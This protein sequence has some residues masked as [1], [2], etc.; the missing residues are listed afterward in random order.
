M[1]H[2]FGIFGLAHGYAHPSLMERSHRHNEIEL[3]FVE[4]GVMTYLFGG[5]QLMVVAGRLVLFWA[6]I[7]HQVVHIEQ[8]VSLHWL[9]VPLAWFL[10]WG[11]PD[12]LTRQVLYGR[13]MV[14]QGHPDQQLDKMLF[15]QWYNDLR[16]DSYER[17]RVV[18]LEIEARLRRLAFSLQTPAEL[19]IV[20]LIFNRGALKKAEQMARFIAERF[21][22]PLDIQTIAQVVNLHPNYAMSLFRKTF[23]MS[24][25]DYL[26]Q[27]RVACAQRLLV[28]TDAKVL[29]IAL[30]SGFGSASRFYEA[31]N[32]ICGQSPGEYRAS[33]N[34][35]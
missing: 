29:D 5:T 34:L 32:R 25:L 27:H 35:K 11:L 23:H 13:P 12:V 17:R 19:E 30:G 9:T 4:E 15:R 16:Q 24:L 14:D 1:T 26:T 33:L 6:A 7:P 31:F 22:E 18:L 2:D 20:P 28:T 8:P 10:Q 3:N 21:A